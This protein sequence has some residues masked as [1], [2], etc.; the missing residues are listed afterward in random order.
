M[1]EAPAG[2]EAIAV[3]DLLVHA[4]IAAAVADELVELLEGALIKQKLDALARR[5]F[6]F[7]VLALAALRPA[8]RLRRPA[9][10][11]QLVHPPAVHVGTRPPV[12]ILAG[13]PRRNRP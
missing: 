3:H 5:H 8:P 6:A 2:D 7:G 9:P 1:D 13:R 4:E 10:L 12:A 11:P